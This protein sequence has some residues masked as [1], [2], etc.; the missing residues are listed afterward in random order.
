MYKHIEDVHVTF[1]R[2]IDDLIKLRHM[3]LP[4]FRPKLSLLVEGQ[5]MGTGAGQGASPGL[6]DT[7]F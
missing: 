2:Q 1:C 5:G 6:T 7:I 3:Q 4:I